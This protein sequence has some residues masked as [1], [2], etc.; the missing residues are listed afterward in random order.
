MVVE[1][2]DQNILTLLVFQRNKNGASF[3]LCVVP[4]LVITAL[5]D[6]TTDDEALITAQVVCVWIYVWG[7]GIKRDCLCRCVHIFSLVNLSSN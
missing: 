1:H 3:T 6:R 2:I 7:G 5:I 4:S